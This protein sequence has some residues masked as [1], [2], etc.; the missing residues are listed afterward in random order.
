MRPHL[1]YHTY[2]KASFIIPDTEA[3]FIIFIVEIRDSNLVAVEGGSNFWSKMTPFLWSIFDA[4]FGP[5]F[6]HLKI[7]F[8]MGIS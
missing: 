4:F 1:L 3:S 5:Y 7:Q 2:Y 8:L 6:V